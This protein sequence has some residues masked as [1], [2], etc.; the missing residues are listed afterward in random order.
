MKATHLFASSSLIFGLIFTASAPAAFA[1]NAAK[2]NGVT[3]S[4]AKV[5]A[6]VLQIRQQQAQQGR[7]QADTPELRTMV[8]DE[9][10]MRE[11]IMQEA[12]YNPGPIDGILR[13]ETMSAVNNYQADKKLPVD[14]YLNVETVKSLGV[15]LR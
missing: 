1:Q 10:I 15:T 11:I 6:M 9:L 14:P 5:D 2:V 7:Q 12:G 13:R 4:S 8:R 3:I